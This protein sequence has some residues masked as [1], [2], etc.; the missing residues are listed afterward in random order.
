MVD[1]APWL[2]V[3]YIDG[4]ALIAFP[5]TDMSESASLAIG[6]QMSDLAEQPDCRQFVINLRLARWLSSTMLGKLMAFQ[7]KAKQRGGDLTLCS[8]SPEL[9]ARFECMRLDRLFHICSTEEEALGEV[10]A[11]VT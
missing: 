10:P 6:R 1:F 3:E 11:G 4:T 5:Q 9:A 8:L 2:H 7:K